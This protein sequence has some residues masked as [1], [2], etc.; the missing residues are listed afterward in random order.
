MLL[1]PDQNTISPVN[2]QAE[3]GHRGDLDPTSE[4]DD[5]GDAFDVE[6]DQ[7][8]STRLDLQPISWFSIGIRTHADGLVSG[9]AKAYLLG[10]D[11]KTKPRQ[12]DY[13]LAVTHGW[14]HSRATTNGSNTSTTV[15]R[16][17]GDAALIGGYRFQPNLLVYGGPFYSK[18]DYRGSHTRTGITQ[19]VSGD[20]YQRGANIGVALDVDQRFRLMLEFVRAAQTARNGNAAP[21]REYT[22][23][24]GL[25]FE[26]LIGGTLKQ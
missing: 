15:V 3:F 23:E 21:L 6:L 11:I 26:F 1:S 13:S 17:Y 7:L 4:D 2:R 22:N 16:D 19:G 24:W 5:L 12:G 25:A 20:V 18:H 14:G 8:F 10:R 9:S